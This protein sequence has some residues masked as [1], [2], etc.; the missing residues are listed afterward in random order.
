MSYFM[1]KLAVGGPPNINKFQPSFYIQRFIYGSTDT[2]KHII[3]SPGF[4]IFST[5][6]SVWLDGFILRDLNV[7]PSF[8]EEVVPK[9]SF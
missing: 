6:V 7:T 5:L 3:E 4:W 9:V 1:W 2:I 8:E